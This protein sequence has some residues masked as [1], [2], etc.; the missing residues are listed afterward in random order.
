[1]GKVRDSVVPGSHATATQ[2]A[3]GSL[4]NFLTERQ[5]L[6]V[7]G[8][9][10]QDHP[11]SQIGTDLSYGCALLTPAAS[12]HANPPVLECTLLYSE[13]AQARGLVFSVFRQQGFT[14]LV[15]STHLESLVWQEGE[16]GENSREREAQLRELSTFASRACAEGGIDAVFVGGDLNHDDH[17][18]SATYSKAKAYIN[19]FVGDFDILDT[20]GIGWHDAYVEANGADFDWEAAATYNGSSNPMLSNNLRRRF[21]RILYVPPPT[22]ASDT[23]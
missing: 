4:L 2:E 22:R 6:R 17:P 8:Q 11:D 16:A 10:M 18:E 23:T 13:S 9:Q 7:H 1:M 14:Y 15:G 21:D 3:T 20:L 12:V 19:K 5:S